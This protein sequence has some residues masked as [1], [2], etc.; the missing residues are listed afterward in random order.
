MTGCPMGISSMPLVGKLTHVIS[1][2]DNSVLIAIMQ[3]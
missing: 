2:A 1:V 3:D